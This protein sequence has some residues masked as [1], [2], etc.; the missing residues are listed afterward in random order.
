MG[1][2]TGKPCDTRDLVVT[3]LCLILMV[4]GIV[5]LATSTVHRLLLY[6]GIFFCSLAFLLAVIYI[7]WRW[8]CR[9]KSDSDNP[10]RDCLSSFCLSFCCCWLCCYGN[11]N[12]C[13]CR[14]SSGDN[15]VFGTVFCMPGSQH[16]QGGTSRRRRNSMTLRERRLANVTLQLRRQQEHQRQ[17]TSETAVRC[18]LRNIECEIQKLTGD[19]EY[20]ERNAVDAQMLRSHYRALVD[21]FLLL[22]G[23][24]EGRTTVTMDQLQ[25][26]KVQLEMI[27]SD[28]KRERQQQRVL[29]R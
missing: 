27:R 8:C 3:C 25:I 4:L 11:D 20:L 14:T 29:V 15:S 17:G 10:S 2:D 26:I 22:S 5:F 16:G 24:I 19:Y 1:D 9:S 21:Q 23:W 18:Q 6:V 28:F 13:C 12:C 7:I